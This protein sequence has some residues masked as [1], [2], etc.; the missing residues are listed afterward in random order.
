MNRFY[1]LIVTLLL[2][3][4]SAFAQSFKVKGNVI[5]SEDKLPVIGATVLIKGTNIGTSTDLIGNFEINIPKSGT[6]LTFSF[7]G[8]TSQDVVV[9]NANPITVV[10]SSDATNIDAVVVTA[11]GIKRSE[12]ALGYSVQ[13]V[14]GEKLTSVKGVDVGSSL[15]GKVAGLLVK[16][17]SDFAVA[18]SLTIR[19]ENPLLVIDGVPYGNM[20]L[21]DIAADDIESLSILK[22]ATASALYGYRGASGALMI[23]TKQGSKEQG[24][25]VSFNSNTMFDAGFLAIP[26]KQGVYGRGSSSGIYSYN[27]DQAWGR[28]IDGSNQMQWDPVTK[29]Y[30]TYPYLPVGAD[31]FKNFLEQSYI[32]NNNISLVYQGKNS[33]VRSSV[34]WVQTKGQYP[35]SVF[36]K[37]SYQLG[38]DINLDKFKF[39]SNVAY[40]KYSSPNAGFN[41]YTN[42][43]PMYTLLIWTAPDYNVLDYKDYWLIKNEKQNFTYQNNTRQGG[44]LTTSHNNPYYAQYEKR[45]II[46]RDIFNASANM[47]YDFTPWLK[48]SFRSGLDFYAD[49]Q[50]IKISKDSYV[51]SGN[52]GPNGGWYGTLDG[53][54]ATGRNSGYSLNND[55]ILTGSRSWGKISVDG[56]IGGTVFY[57]Q[58]N[59]MAGN[60]VNGISIPG[61]FS[62]NA[63]VDK[64]AV[65]STLYR[66]QVNS[67]FGRLALS[68]GKMIFVDGTLRNDWSSTLPASTRSYL[69]PSVSGSFVASELLPQ[70]ANWLSMWKIRG[71]WTMSKTP[72]DIYATNSVF[73]VANSAWGTNASAYLPGSLIATDVLPQAASTLEVGTQVMLWNNRL[74]VDVSY[75]D[76]LMYDFLKSAAI[77]PA[78]GFSSSYLN[79]DEQISRRGWELTLNGSIIKNSDWSWDMGVNWST[80]A[81]YYTKL[82]AKYSTDKPWVKVGERVDAYVLNDYLRDPATGSVIYSNGVA[83]FA[84]YTSNA[85]WSD[86]DWIW[87]VNSVVSYKNFSLT[88]SFDGRVG[89]LT[90]SMTESYLW[91]SGNHPES[92]TESRVKD[93]ATPGSKNYIGEG[94]KVVSGTVAFDV[95]GNITS[96]TRVFAANDIAVTYQ[97]HVNRIHSGIAWGGSGRPA[98]LFSTTFIKLRELSLTYNLPKSAYSTFG[99]KGASL[100]FIGQNLWFWAK[101]FRYS[102]PDGGTDNFNDPSLRYLGFNIKLNF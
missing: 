98:D 46:N 18:P 101:D 37:Y 81:R 12:K 28:V 97:S 17:S 75:Y 93:V 102:D 83:Q 44:N 92:L 4:S 43:D 23:T 2:I 74:M 61:F 36:D 87:G 41:G 57:K 77:S 40:H 33:S 45:N 64:A 47:S 8:M 35:N 69:Y 55:L 5:S 100:S 21:R 24:V 42:Y 53:A 3:T 56:L 96:D 13:K 76:K 54:Y 1:F 31:N 26:E 52:T 34:S 91:N 48:L 25:Q 11:L 16:N 71:S 94:V 70:T 14:S 19:G 88:L 32:T 84:S 6:T 73:T 38:G 78:S 99:A 50:D 15:T 9:Q 20:T 66:Q 85:G 62:L 30:A 89:G 22:G 49:R 51:S 60:T 67:L 95:Y 29:A 82:D 58:D 68:W 86:P 10:L 90:N 27:Q 7:I 59:T 65:V 80:Y 63:S 79:I 39:S 72:A